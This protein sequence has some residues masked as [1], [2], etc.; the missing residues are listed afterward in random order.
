MWLPNIFPKETL[1]KVKDMKK[2]SG[3]RSVLNLNADGSLKQPPQFTPKRSNNG[4]SKKKNEY[5]RSQSRGTQFNQRKKEN[6]NSFKTKESFRTTGNGNT[7]TQKKAGHKTLVKKGN[8]SQK[9]RTNKVEVNLA[10]D[11][12][13]I[14][15]GGRL[16]RFRAAWKGANYKSVVKKGL[17]L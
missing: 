16:F 6:N 9:A 11:S 14:P 5:Q 4:N 3:L 10:N 2:D 1:E 7:S 8:T 13:K 17:P 12:L 15:V